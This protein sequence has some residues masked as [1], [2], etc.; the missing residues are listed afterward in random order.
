MEA[1]DYRELIALVRGRLR[2]VGLG[3]LA[4]TSRYAIY[5]PDAEESRL[6]PLRGLLIEM[7]AALER[8]VATRDPGLA[9]FALDRINEVLVDGYVEDVRF[10][11]VP[12][13][14]LADPRSL[15]ELPEIDELRDELSSL[16]REIREL[17]DR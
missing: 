8:H 10:E 13:D 15:R 16:I 5:D 1:N 7:L 9:D 11:P 6:P 3:T 2:E 17:A 14:S 12:D 4:D